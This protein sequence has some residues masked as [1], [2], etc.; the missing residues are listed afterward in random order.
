MSYLV[1]V[2]ILDIGTI[3]VPRHHSLRLPPSPPPLPPSCTVLS[4]IILPLFESYYV[5]VIEDLSATKEELEDAVVKEALY[6]APSGLN[7]YA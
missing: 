1:P 2:L 7:N 3:P 4:S 6:W 5:H